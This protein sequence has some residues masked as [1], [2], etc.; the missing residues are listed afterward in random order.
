MLCKCQLLQGAE[1]SILTD[2]N[3]TEKFI[4]NSS[5]LAGDKFNA[6]GGLQEWRLHQ[7]RNPFPYFSIQVQALSSE[8]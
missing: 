1:F 7:L 2:I 4:M 6:F 3:C 8:L 5:F